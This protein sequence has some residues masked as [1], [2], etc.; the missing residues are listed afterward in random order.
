MKRSLVLGSLEL[1]V[2]TELEV[3]IVRLPS[4]ERAVRFEDCTGTP[5]DIYVECF[6]RAVAWVDEILPQ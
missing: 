2:P 1:Y 4:G 5:P 6:R 3:Q